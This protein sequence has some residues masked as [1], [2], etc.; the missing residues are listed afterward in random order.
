MTSKA[1]AKSKE[2]S[3]AAISYS[4]PILR[5]IQ[6]K[7]DIQTVV[8]GLYG[9]TDLQTSGG[10]YAMQ[11]LFRAAS[12]A[13][14]P[15][16]TS[17]SWQVSVGDANSWSE[18]AAEYS[19][20]RVLGVEVEYNVWIASSTDGFGVDPVFSGVVRDNTTPTFTG[21]VD[22][23]TTVMH[24]VNIGKNVIKREMRM[25]GTD[26]AEWVETTNVYS[27]ISPTP[28][29][30]LWAQDSPTLRRVNIFIRWRVQ[31]RTRV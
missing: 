18:W 7:D 24:P 19:A 20:F 3:I 1:R 8:L 16:T 29:L 15:A 30:F 17:G 10:A 6:A 27:P 2:S 9:N 25:D 31:F 23:P 4:G 12:S 14:I 28:R 5:P 22:S 13:S 26:E 21:I 11:V